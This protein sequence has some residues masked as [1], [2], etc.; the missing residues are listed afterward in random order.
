MEELVGKRKYIYEVTPCSFSTPLSVH[1]PRTNRCYSSLAFCFSLSFT[2][3]PSPTH[4]RPCSCLK[5]NPWS[6]TGKTL[7]RMRLKTR[8]R[9]CT[10]IV[11][12]S[13]RPV[14]HCQPRF[15]FRSEETFSICRASSLVS[16][17][18]FRMP[19]VDADTV[20]S[21]CKANGYPCYSCALLLSLSLVF[22]LVSF[23][24]SY[25]VCRYLSMLSEHLL[26]P[27]PDLALLFAVA[28]FGVY[29]WVILSLATPSCGSFSPPRGFYRFLTFPPLLNTST[30]RA[31]CR[32]SLMI[33]VDSRGGDTRIMSW[34]KKVGEGKKR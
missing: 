22:F 26:D 21:F 13:S 16:S 28:F 33:P 31:T 23:Y 2:P 25:V 34:C 24:S 19:D 9:Q 5:T 10:R 8:P 32:W 11:S 6:S 1:G 18:L 4:P 30:Y 15:V 27:G 17:P 12:C 3:I 20:F 29:A 7:L 14:R